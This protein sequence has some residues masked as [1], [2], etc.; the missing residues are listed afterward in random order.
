MLQ[1]YI[2]RVQGPQSFAWIS[3]AKITEFLN[4]RGHCAPASSECNSLDAEYMSC[5]LDKVFG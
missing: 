1:R 2:Q 3:P 5:Y 4:S